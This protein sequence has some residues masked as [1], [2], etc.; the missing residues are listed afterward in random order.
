MAKSLKDW[1]EDRVDFT[2]KGQKFSE[3]VVA[4]VMMRDMS[5]EEIKQLLNEV[6][7]RQS[8]WK[9]MAVGIEREI[10]D[11]EED[12]EIWFQECYM[13]V[14][15]EYGKKT[16]SWKKSKIILDN[17]EEYKRRKAEIRDLQDVGKK[18]GVITGGYNTLTWTLRE[19][20]RLTYQEIA[21]LNGAP[22]ASGSLADL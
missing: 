12:F 8:Y 9:S 2:F 18:I 20:A 21:G 15:T 4:N 1:T 14:D 13:D 17:T 5:V 22:K 11:L 16:E 3:P 6:P 7:A 19:I 10:A